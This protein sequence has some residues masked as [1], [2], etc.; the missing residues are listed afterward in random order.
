[1][2]RHLLIA[3][4]ASAL[5]LP[6]TA[7]TAAVTT[8]TA[9][10]SAPVVGAPAPVVAGLDKRDD[11]TAI[12][13]ERGVSVAEAAALVDWQNEFAIAATAIEEKFPGSFTD[14]EIISEQPAVARIRF[15]GEVP[16]GVKDLLADLP[17]NIEVELLGGE[18]RSAEEIN[19]LVITAHEQA[20]RRNPGIGDHVTEYN[21]STG[22][23]TMVAQSTGLPSQ[24]T[25]ASGAVESRASTER[26]LSAA[27]STDVDIPVSLDLIFGPVA[28]KEARYGGG[29]LEKN[30]RSA[31]ACTA[32]FNVQRHGTTGIATA[33]HCPNGLTHENT[34]GYD[35][36]T[37]YFEDEYTGKWGDFQWGTTTDTEV[38]RFYASYS[39]TR[40][41][42]SVANPTKGQ[43]LCRF[44]H[45]TGYE[46][47][48]VASTS[49][50]CITTNG[51]KACHLVR[52]KEDEAEG[53]D[54]GGPWFYNYAA[55]GF[56]TGWTTCGALWS[57][58]CDVWSRATLID[59][60]LGVYVLRT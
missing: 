10:E 44:G 11:L 18:K 15:K 22:S 39:S 12:A 16:A 23:I 13:E 59:D 32:G 28:G 1:M 3:L 41:V 40:I 8:P 5:L 45:K 4:S 30:G 49:G 52:M 42:T 56:H 60:A 7:A 51:K 53:G 55:Y 48:T 35:E 37:V 17:D 34:S 27:L 9:G 58:T 50:T 47:G 26:R 54:S 46:C 21:H 25:V 43:T 57:S 38:A 33:G 20:E 2:K 31:L 19:S 24:R 29:R 14:A 6:A 36:Y